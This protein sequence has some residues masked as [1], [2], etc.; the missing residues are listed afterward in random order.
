M[1][2]ASIE[3]WLTQLETALQP[4]PADERADIVGE[5]RTHLEERLDAGLSPASAL[6]GFGRAE[7]Y[8]RDFLDDHTVTSALDSKRAFAMVKALVS[9]AGQSIV[10]T[11]GLLCFLV[12]GATTL[13]SIACIL[14]KI[15]RPQMVGLWSG[16]GTFAFGAISDPPATPELLGNWAYVVLIALIIVD[17]WLARFSLIAALKG[18]KGRTIT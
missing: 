16:D 9:V 10:A 4:L 8:A 5:A 15:A 1:S 11:I 2:D 7:S 12:F 17:A 18:L 13:A 3:T 14:I 6:A